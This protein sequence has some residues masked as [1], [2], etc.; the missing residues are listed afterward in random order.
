MNWKKRIAVI[1][2]NFG[3]AFITPLS[4]L[5]IFAPGIDLLHQIIV[6]IWVAGLGAFLSIFR[7]LAD[8]G[9]TENERKSRN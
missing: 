7:E 5:S 1:V 2:G 8:W 9:A 6:S 4:G 3:I